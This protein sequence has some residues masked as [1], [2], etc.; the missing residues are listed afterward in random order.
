M[1]KEGTGDAP[2]DPREFA[3]GHLGEWLG[4]RARLER[5]VLDWVVREARRLDGLPVH[6]GWE[7]AD[8]GKE[9]ESRVGASRR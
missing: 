9:R 8:G 6:T 5:Q 4:A 2:P 3:A 1:Y 7:W